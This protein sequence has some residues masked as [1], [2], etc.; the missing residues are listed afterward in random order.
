MDLTGLVVIAATAA[1]SFYAK[2]NLLFKFTIL[3]SLVCYIYAGTS[4]AFVTLDYLKVI[5]LPLVIL[6]NIY[7]VVNWT[8]YT[9]SL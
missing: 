5:V 7:L 1:A 6:I 8:K 4:F 9:W 3:V 2:V